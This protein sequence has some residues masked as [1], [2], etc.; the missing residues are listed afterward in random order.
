MLR[1]PCARDKYSATSSGESFAE[2]RQAVRLLCSLRDAVTEAN[3]PVPAA[4]PS[5]CAHGLRVLLRPTP[6]VG[7]DALE[8]RAELC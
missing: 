7:E 5:F 1:K 4:T 6:P 3:M 8:E 2:R